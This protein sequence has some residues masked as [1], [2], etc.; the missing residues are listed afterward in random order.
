MGKRKK[1]KE[2]KDLNALRR[3]KTAPAPLLWEK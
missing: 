1:K 3:E 2:E